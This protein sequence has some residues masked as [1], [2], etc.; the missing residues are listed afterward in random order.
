MQPKKKLIRARSTYRCLNNPL[1]TENDQRLN[2]EHISQT[3]AQ[4]VR[5]SRPISST[6]NRP[7]KCQ[8]TQNSRKNTPKRG[9]FQRPMSPL[10]PDQ[11]RNHMESSMFHNTLFSS[12]GF[13]PSISSIYICTA[14]SI[15]RK[16]AP[17]E[18]PSFSLA[19]ETL[20]EDEKP[21]RLKQDSIPVQKMAVET[22]SLDH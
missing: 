21:V 20:T 15:N 9:L 5:I 14:K 3:S 4:K 7:P 19:A 6:R 17:K 16:M 18:L 10:L 13:K 22:L 8:T 12:N 2:T 1:I 11:S